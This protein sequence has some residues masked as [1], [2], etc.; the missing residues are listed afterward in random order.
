MNYT[1]IASKHLISQV[2]K[3]YK[4]VMAPY[5]GMVALAWD[6]KQLTRGQPKRFIEIYN[7]AGVLLK[8]VTY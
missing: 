2:L 1:M 4:L 8:W 6:S 5:G 7:G 3:N